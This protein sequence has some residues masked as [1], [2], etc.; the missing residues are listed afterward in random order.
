MIG[1][2][3]KHS[4]W[5][6]F[7]IIAAVI[8]SFVFYFSPSSRM[9]NGDS[10][11]SYQA[12]CSAVGVIGYFGRLFHGQRGRGYSS[13]ALSVRGGRFEQCRDLLVSTSGCCRQM[14]SSAIGDMM[15]RFSEL[16]VDG[17]SPSERRRVVGGGAH[18]RMREL[19]PGRTHPDQ[20]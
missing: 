1:T 16:A 17:G 12:P 6:W 4:S 9:G 10:G 18:Q 15:Q 11:G 8:V 2:I 7:I 3:R 20:S 13:A 19:H 14:P 5:L